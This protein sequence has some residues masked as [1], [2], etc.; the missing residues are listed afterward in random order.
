MNSFN[1]TTKSKKKSNMTLWMKI[2]SFDSLFTSSAAGVRHLGI[3][4]WWM[5]NW[6]SFSK[7]MINWD[8]TLIWKCYRCSL[9]LMLCTTVSWTKKCKPT[10]TYRI[11]SRYLVYWIARWWYSSMPT[12]VEIHGAKFFRTRNLHILFKQWNI[13]TLISFLKQWD[14]LVCCLD[15]FDS[16]YMS[17][18]K[19]IQSD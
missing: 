8:D 11:S 5:S 4:N 9:E 19:E 18:R 3:Q 10:T 2:N 1:R 12:L 14:F 15:F 16:Y 6:I 7:P 17:H 13:S